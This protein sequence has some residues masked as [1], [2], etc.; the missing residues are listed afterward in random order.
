MN[1][2]L[3]FT[4][5]PRET[6][7]GQPRAPRP[8]P[9]AAI[10]AVREVRDDRAF[11]WLLVFTLVLFLRPQDVFPPLEVF[12]LAELSA[13]AGLLSLFAGRLMRGERLTRLTPEFGAVLAFAAVILLTAPFSLWFGGSVGVFTDMY[14]KVVLVYL[15][16]VNAIASPKRLER[17]TWV[18]VLAVGFIGFR[19]VVDY[20][21][22][23]NLTA[24]GTRV[25]GSVGGIMENPNDLALN[26]VVFLPPAVFIALGRKNVLRR[27]IAAGCALFMVGAIV[28]SGSRGG[29]LGFV[30]MLVVL[31]AVMVRRRPMVVVAGV[32]VVMCALPV[33]PAGY[34]RRI[35]SIT[36]RSKDDSGSA[37][38]RETLMRESIQAYLEH[39]FIGVGAGEFKDWNN[40]RRVES[41]HESH[42]VWLQVASELGTVGLV[43]FVFLV[44]RGPIAVYQTRR[45]LRRADLWKRAGAP[46]LLTP[47]EREALDS[48]SAAIAASLAGW[49]VCA[50]FA[51]VAYNWTFYYLLALAATPREIIRDRLPRPV[52]AAHAAA[53]K[54]IRRMVL[55][56][57][58][59]ARA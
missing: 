38:A 53:A 57:G 31:A 16:A 5:G 59:E 54:G 10:P 13:I 17:L 58:R 1:E 51:S 55:A 22:G 11:N 12:H 36:D 4:F 40:D 9:V 21:R 24:R 25:R 46:P 23:E 15:L 37:E 47:D 3:T 56:G 41:W 6:V 33:L 2:R 14:A 50:F 29:F 44:L 42:N 39:P 32:L 35:A 30:F 8:E 48:H 43:V 45:L 28:A 19:A 18:L 26:M 52:R 7:T 27:L 49:L 20:A 34:W